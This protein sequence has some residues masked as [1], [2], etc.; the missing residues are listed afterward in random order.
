M[1]EAASAA[2]GRP[3]YGGKSPVAGVAGTPHGSHPAPGRPVTDIISR[4]ALVIRTG[5]FEFTECSIRQQL[6][7]LVSTRRDSEQVCVVID[8]SSP[9]RQ[10]YSC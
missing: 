1:V 9:R 5:H 7:N 10:N 3:R 2:E 6:D 8:V 4:K